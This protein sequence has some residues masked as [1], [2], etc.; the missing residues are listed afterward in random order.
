MDKCKDRKTCP[1]VVRLRKANVS[2]AK[3]NMLLR[4]KKDVPHTNSLSRADQARRIRIL[5]ASVSWHTVRHATDV[6]RIQ[7]LETRLAIKKS[8]IH[9]KVAKPAQLMAALRL[10][11]E[12]YVA[13]VKGHFGQA[14]FVAKVLLEGE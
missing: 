7:E 2:L 11:S 5:S 4:T 14:F 12:E 6:E 3:K 13:K 1:I 9:D 8:G 10:L